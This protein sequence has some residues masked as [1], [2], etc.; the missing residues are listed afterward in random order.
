V[1]ETAKEGGGNLLESNSQSK[2]IPKDAFEKR[3]RYLLNPIA[4][5]EHPR[6]RTIG[7]RAQELRRGSPHVERVE[8]SL[9]K[10]A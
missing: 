5:N 7:F 2:S 1:R 3:G 4:R 9:E 10:S 8:G 6:R